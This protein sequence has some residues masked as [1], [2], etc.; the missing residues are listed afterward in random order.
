MYTVIL[1]DKTYYDYWYHT[2]NSFSLA[3]NFAIEHYK[4]FVRL[5]DKDGHTIYNNVEYNG[6]GGFTFNYYCERIG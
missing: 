3:L 1:Q 5:D 6:L 2:F 4:E